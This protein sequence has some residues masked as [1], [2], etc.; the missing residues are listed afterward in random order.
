M[1]DAIAT[2][3]MPFVQGLVGLAATVLLALLSSWVHA[4]VKNKRIVDFTARL[5]A[6]VKT[7]VDSVA[8]AAVASLPPGNSLNPTAIANMKIAARM[9][10]VQKLGGSAG[11]ELAKSLLGYKSTDDLWASLDH[12]IEAAIGDWVNGY[13]KGLKGCRP[14][15]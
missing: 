15:N 6:A 13:S 8:T 9:A 4:H 7:V 14:Q 10:L 1:S 11:I 5:V 12:D 3:L 2:T